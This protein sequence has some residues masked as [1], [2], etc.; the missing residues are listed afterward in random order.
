MTVGF[1]AHPGACEIRKSGQ[2]LTVL[3]T[4]NTFGAGFS[5]K[6]RKKRPPLEPYWARFQGKPNTGNGGS[7]HGGTHFGS[8]K[9]PKWTPKPPLFGGSF[10]GPVEWEMGS[11]S[12]KKGVQNCHFPR[13]LVRKPQILVEIPILKLPEVIDLGGGGPKSVI[14]GCFY[15]F[16]PYLAFLVK[17]GVKNTIFGRFL[18]GFGLEFMVLS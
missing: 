11:K 12:A 18:N 2:F 1:H 14:L 3:E 8:K 6:R 17:K 10:F 7:D 9:G 13:G 15:P 5:K 16:C 4:Q